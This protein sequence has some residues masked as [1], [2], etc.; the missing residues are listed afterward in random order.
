MSAPVGILPTVLV[1]PTF[2]TA[3]SHRL[4]SGMDPDTIALEAQFGITHMM[5]EYAVFMRQMV[6][7]LR[8]QFES[9]HGAPHAKS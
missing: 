9:T 5:R 6:G 1:V 8:I 2:E 4:P 7:D 3:I